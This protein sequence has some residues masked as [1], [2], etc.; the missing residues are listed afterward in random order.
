[1]ATRR[2]AGTVIIDGTDDEFFSDEHGHLKQNVD[3]I[4]NGGQ[5]ASVIKVPYLR[6]GGECRVELQ[7]TAQVVQKDAVQI[8]GTAKLFE[9]TSESTNDLEDTKQINFTI[10]KGGIPA[11]RQINLVSTEIGGGD[12]AEIR[13]TL[14]NSIFESP[15]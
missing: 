5:P 2:I 10:P 9:G 3:A 4:L 14:T 1:M 15:D 8:T 6:W 11:H 13:I 7:L 12:H